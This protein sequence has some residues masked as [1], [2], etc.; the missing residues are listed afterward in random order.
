MWIVVGLSPWNVEHVG[1]MD[2]VWANF[3]ANFGS[4]CTVGPASELYRSYAMPCDCRVVD[5]DYC[6]ETPRESS[7]LCKQ[8]RAF[9]N[10]PRP[11]LEMI[12]GRYTLYNV[13]F[14]VFVS[15]SV[16]NHAVREG[17]GGRKSGDQRLCSASLPPQPRF[18]F[19][20]LV[21]SMNHKSSYCEGSLILSP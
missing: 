4:Q 8:L 21:L 1:G 2:G 16:F 19:C 5:L 13:R 9:W 6:D 12:Q 11:S 7:S 3:E 17:E 15:V 20:A 14:I 18:P 10:F